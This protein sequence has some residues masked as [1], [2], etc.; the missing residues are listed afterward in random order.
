MGSTDQVCETSQKVLANGVPFRSAL[1]RLLGTGG[2]WRVLFYML[3][4]AY[5]I[6]YFSLR[7]SLFA[8]NRDPKNISAT[9]DLLLPLFRIDSNQTSTSKTSYQLP[10]PKTGVSY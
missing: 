4:R 6:F 9:N 10:S 5:Q 7:P 8:I 2:R 1:Y 3:A